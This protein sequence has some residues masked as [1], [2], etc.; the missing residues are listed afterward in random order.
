[1]EEIE[2]PLEQA[3]EEIHH[4][5]QHGGES[6]IMK[7]ALLSAFLAVFAAIAALLAGHYSNEAM[8][9]QLHASDFWSHYQAKSIKGSVLE[10][11]KD[12]LANLGKAVDPKI[13]EKLNEYKSEQKE[14]AEKADEQ[15]KE[16]RVHL[17]KH[18]ILARAVT[19]FQIAIAVTAIA[20]LVKR[21]QFLVV[22]CFFGIC[23]LFFLIQSFLFSGH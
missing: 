10:M 21:K 18:Q 15:E 9:E 2:V 5:A 4:H 22:S 1:M 7:G 8:L 19:L 12:V 3:Q 6:W 23:G 20:V 14:L 11:R 17:E 13:D 16:S